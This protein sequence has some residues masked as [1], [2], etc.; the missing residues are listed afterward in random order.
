[1]CSWIFF[2]HCK[3]GFLFCENKLP[4]WSIYER[5]WELDSYECFCDPRAGK[6]ILTVFAGAFIAD[7]SRRPDFH[8]VPDPQL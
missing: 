2:S 8:G 5:A 1:M 4:E 3:D 7:S 6:A